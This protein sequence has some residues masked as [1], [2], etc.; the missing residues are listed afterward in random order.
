MRTNVVQSANHSAEFLQKKNTRV[1]KR[2]CQATNNVQRVA[3]RMS[4]NHARIRCC[5]LELGRFKKNKGIGGWEPVGPPGSSS[6]STIGD[7][8]RLVQLSRAWKVSSGSRSSSRRSRKVRGK[9][10][11]SSDYRA[12][13]ELTPNS[14]KTR[15][16]RF[17]IVCAIGLGCA[18]QACVVPALDCAPPTGRPSRPETWKR[19]GVGSFFRHVGS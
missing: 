14:D 15:W 18:G 7:H 11:V 13:S 5:S 19:K 3:N 9:S 4:G 8:R 12:N 2:A 1:R 17:V 16:L 6:A 10:G